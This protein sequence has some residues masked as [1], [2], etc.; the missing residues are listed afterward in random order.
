MSHLQSYVQRLLAI[1]RTE[2]GDALVIDP[3]SIGD[4]F[5]TLTLMDAFR[6]VHGIKHIQLLCRPRVARV[7]SLFENIDG[8]LL[9]DAIDEEKLSLL[10]QTRWFSQQNMVFV[11][12][13]E[14]HVNGNI[15]LEQ[16]HNC[17]IMQLKKK[18]LNLPDDTQ[19][20]L[21]PHSEFIVN[22]ARNS[23]LRQ[24]VKPG[25]VIIF[26]HAHTMKP[27]DTDVY[28]PLAKL[29]PGG[30]FFDGWSGAPSGW[31]YRLNIPLEQ[32]PYFC[33]VAGTA[34]CI[35]SGITELLSLS[36]A[37]IHTIYP[38]GNWMAPWFKNKADTAVMF[39]E[40]GIRDLG[41]NPNS[42]EEK[43]FIENSDTLQTIAEKIL[44]AVKVGSRTS[45]E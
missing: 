7:F 39:R 45:A 44:R 5:Q 32:A 11:A 26:N 37:K 23:A 41:L 15:F 9:T 19:P 3:Y 4:V 31:G 36:N 17:H 25:S 13:P 20:V 28:R 2:P 21:P 35:R 10:A 22:K 1:T 18:V 30:V 42:H 6:K 27:M 12:P 33:D 43:L 40:W 34:I 8:L 29:F 24:G 38:G 14:M 16:S